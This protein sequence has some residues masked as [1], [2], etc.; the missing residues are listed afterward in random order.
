M[1]KLT[2]GRM[3]KFNKNRTEE[4]DSSSFSS[5]QNFKRHNKDKEHTLQ[6][7]RCCSSLN[8]LFFD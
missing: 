6:K 3:K 4:T 8:I 1:E 2:G 5:S 7:D